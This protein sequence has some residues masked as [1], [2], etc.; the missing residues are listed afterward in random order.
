MQNASTQEA[1]KVEHNPSQ[2]RNKT[3]ALAS[4]NSASSQLVS[5]DE[6][7]QLEGLIREQD[8]LIK[9]EQDR[10]AN[11][12]QNNIS[13]Y[14]DSNQDLVK[15]LIQKKIGSGNTQR[16]RDHL[17]AELQ[18][19]SGE[20]TSGEVVMGDIRTPGNRV[21]PRSGELQDSN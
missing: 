7:L 6:L 9:D 2:L 14:L 10:L 13:V 21:T 20:L 1:I 18:M 16:A 15:R 12:Y 4:Q 11:Q 17:D 19:K 3:V 8:P 5:Q